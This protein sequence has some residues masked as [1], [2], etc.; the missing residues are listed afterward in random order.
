MYTAGGPDALID[1]IIGEENYKTG[2]WQS[3]E[4]NDFEAIIDLKSN[5]PVEYIGIHVLQDVGSWIW[6]PKYVQYY[7][8]SDGKV[9]TDIG[10]AE[11]QVSDK[12]YKASHQVLGINTKMT[13]RYIK[14]VAKNYG[15]VP[16]W[17]PGKGG[18]SHIFIDEVIVK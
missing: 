18:K 17:H 10:R 9:F 7:S 11:H 3:Y 8:S 4:G 1:N 5:R 12:D 14:I 15:T 6:L 2:E 16:D 13:T